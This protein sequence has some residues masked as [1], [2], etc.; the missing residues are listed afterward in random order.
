MDA[1]DYLYI[2]YKEI[3]SVVLATTDGDGHP[4][5][6]YM[7]VMYADDTGIYFMTSKGKDIYQRMNTCDYVSL[8]GMTG[9]NFFDSKMIT[10]RGR[11]RNIGSEKVELLFDKNPYMYKIYPSAENRDVIDVFQI[12]TGQGEYSD[13]SVQPPFRA[14]FSFGGGTVIKNGYYISESCNGCGVCT[15]KCPMHCIEKGKPYK[16]FAEHC[17][18][19]G[20]CY[21]HC[22]IQ[23]V[24]KILN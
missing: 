17:M 14:V 13:F 12:Y 4:A 3:H 1:Q 9:N 22:P 18:H 5:T 7:D 21:Y 15:E 2:L 20:N 19:C 10:V 16:I 11:I 8:T 6:A 24:K 23:A